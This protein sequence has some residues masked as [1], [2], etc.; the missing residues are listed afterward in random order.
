MTGCG[1]SCITLNILKNHRI[2]NFKWVDNVSIKLL[3]RERKKERKEERPERKREGGRKEGRTGGEWQHQNVQNGLEEWRMWGY[4]V[5]WMG[6]E[7]LFNKVTFISTEVF[8]KQRN[9]LDECLEKE[10]PGR[11]NSKYK[12]PVVDMCVITAF[13]GQQRGPRS[14]SSLSEETGTRNRQAGPVHVRP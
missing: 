12:S 8:R 4:F 2:V 11:G 13:E 5:E 3:Q 6:L 1:D 14:G 7:G 9:E 10:S